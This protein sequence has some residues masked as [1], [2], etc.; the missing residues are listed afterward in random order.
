MPGYAITFARLR[1]HD[2]A[3]YKAPG[4]MIKGQT[5]PP[6]CYL[7][8]DIIALRHIF[9]IALSQFFRDRFE[10]DQANQTVQ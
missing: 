7:D 4:T 10:K 3:F 2:I 9:A 1:P 6:V 5:R 8:N